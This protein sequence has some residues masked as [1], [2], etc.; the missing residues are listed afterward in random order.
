MQQKPPF[1][2]IDLLGKLAPKITIIDAGAM[3][4]SG[5]AFEGNEHR[6]LLK[7]GLG[8][9]IG[10]EPV[11]AECDK[12]NAGVAARGAK[13]SEVYLPY[14]VGDGSKRTFHIC[15]KAMTSSLY[16]PN[17][18]L[19]KLFQNLEELVRVVSTEEM[20]SKRL[21]DLPEVAE[22]DY[23]KLD[24]QGAELDVLRGATNRLKRVVVVNTEVEFVPLYKDQ[25]LFA[26]VDAYLRSQ[27][28]LLHALPGCVGRAFKPIQNGTNINQQ[29]NQVLWAQVTYVKDFTKLDRLEPEQLLR[30]AVIMHEVFVSVDLA[31]LALFHYDRKMKKGLWEVYVRRLTGA[32]GEIKPPDVD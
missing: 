14:A 20:E 25:P 18:G 1:S 4:L 10:F 9:V 17:T 8:R 22:T 30:L 26:D 27:G 32:K 11:K 24:I 12:L 7:N 21:D 5:A 16:E 15:N 28:F 23:L 29:F 31:S 13:A 2:L 6:P 19:L 3:E